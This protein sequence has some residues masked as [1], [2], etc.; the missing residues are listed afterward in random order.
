A[1]AYPRPLPASSPSIWAGASALISRVSS[2]TYGDAGSVP[3]ANGAAASSTRVCTKSFIDCCP[4][5]MPPTLPL[6][7]RSTPTQ[8]ARGRSAYSRLP[9]QRPSTLIRRYGNSASW[10]RL[11]ALHFVNALRTACSLEVRPDV[12]AQAPRPDW[13]NALCPPAAPYPSLKSSSARVSCITD[14]SSACGSKIRSAYGA[15]LPDGTKEGPVAHPHRSAT[16]M[17]RTPLPTLSPSRL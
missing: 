2:P 17:T 5:K 15:M 1:F 16:K 4:M 13:A 8:Q 11:Y 12:Q 6:Q 3:Y 10:P 7:W 9:V 14:S